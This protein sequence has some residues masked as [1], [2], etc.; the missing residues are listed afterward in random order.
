MVLTFKGYEGCAPAAVSLAT[1]NQ[2]E[3]H[4][5]YKNGSLLLPWVAGLLPRSA[6]SP[7]HAVRVS[8][9]DL[10]SGMKDPH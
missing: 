6:H 9:Q 2:P 8:L 1:E 10:A 3:A 7:M 5:P 4:F